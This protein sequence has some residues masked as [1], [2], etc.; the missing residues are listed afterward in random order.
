MVYDDEFQR[1]M[2]QLPDEGAERLER[3][4][5]RVHAGDSSDYRT[6]LYN[7]ES[8]EGLLRRFE[9]VVGFTDFERY[10]D[11]DKTEMDK[12]GPYSIM[13]PSDER[14]PN[15]NRYWKQSWNPDEG[16][17][18]QALSKVKSLVPSRSLRPASFDTAFGLMPKDTNLGLPWFTRDRGKAESY[19]ERAISAQ[20]PSDWY[21]CVWFWRG[22]P[23]GMT[24]IPK[25]RDVW[26]YDHLDTIVCSTLL[27][28]LLEVLRRHPYFP[29]WTGDAWVDEG[30]TRILNKSQGRQ[31][32]SG[33]YS[34]FDSSLARPMLDL[35]DEVLC[36][37]FVESVHA[38]ILLL[39]EVNATI[40]IVVPYRLLKGRNGAMTSGTGLTNA[41][42]SIVNLLAIHYA[43]E[44]LGVVVEDCMVLGDDF[45]VLYDREVSPEAL[46]QVMLEIGLSMNAD[47]Q[48]IDTKSIHFLQRWHSLDYL[49]DGVARGCHS[50]YRTFS[51]LVG[52][53]R[54]RWNRKG[55]P[56]KWNKYMD[57]ARW[58]MQAEVCHNDPRH[59]NLCE[60]ILHGDEILLS[61]MDPVTVFRR[62]GGSD[63]I[64]S[65]LNIASFPFNVKNPELVR[66]FETT[67]VIRE[68]QGH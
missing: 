9:E 58:I 63:A 8:R 38:R 31:I 37:W 11:I 68:L 34:D 18:T 40:P 26:G 24:E 44:R 3:F 4:L 56:V 23:K 35:A 50:P 64:R 5:D 19:L 29:A 13:L 36:D 49:I 43:A 17:L 65:L 2:G 7:R 39:G 41:K 21:P 22:Q 55:D 14:L 46:E 32:I 54:M 25:Q 33:D 15:L 1:F 57:S 62:A 30:S 12:V 10:T 66:E 61:G 16:A 28:P 59:R 45:V 47:K 60:F 67:R 48:Y 42:D 52:Y 6:P 53:E 27:R 20:Q 51:G